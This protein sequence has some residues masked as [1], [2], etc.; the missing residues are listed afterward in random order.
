MNPVGAITLDVDSL[1][2]YH[3]IHGLPAPP[4]ERDPIYTVALPRFY[5]LLERLGLKATL[6]LIGGDIEPHKAI[7]GDFSRLGCE[8]ANHSQSHD[9]RLSR[10]PQKTIQDELQATEAILQ[11]ISGHRPVGF[12][13]PGYNISPTLLET[14]I[15]RGYLYDSSLLPSFPYFAAR[16]AVIGLYRL[17]KRRSASLVGDPRA[18]AGPL[19]PYRA[20]PQNPWKPHPEG[21]LE[22]P[23]TAMPYLRVPIIGTSW[24][25]LP[26]AIRPS[27]LDFTLSRLPFFHFELHAIDLLDATDPGI[28]PELV[29]KQPDLRR[30][31]FE[32]IDGLRRLAVGLSMNRPVL[33]LSDIAKSLS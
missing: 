13:A 20:D 9:Y 2:C 3:A 23:M 1:R 7:L 27:L 24:S 32:K 18:Y 33:T 19:K 4:P 25:L 11:E 29:A 21:L 8:L 5:D 12:R 28:T 10:R 14:L 16:A 22:L 6:F 17:Q 26:K 30:P 31:W 15:E